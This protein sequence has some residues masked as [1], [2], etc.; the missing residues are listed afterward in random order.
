M[1]DDILKTAKIAAYN[2][3]Q[4]VNKDNE[5]GKGPKEVPF[6]PKKFPT[7]AVDI[8]FVVDGLKV[9]LFFEPNSC[10]WD[11]DITINGMH[12]KLSPD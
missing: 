8:I 12:A 10:Q 4:V 6:N 9:E 1:T 7:K 3:G 5:D 2:V 11:S